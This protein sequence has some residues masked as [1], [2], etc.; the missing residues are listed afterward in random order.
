[1]QKCG[2]DSSPANRLGTIKWLDE[3]FHSKSVERVQ[4]LIQ[5]SKYL[6]SSSYH[7]S[8]ELDVR[9]IQVLCVISYLEECICFLAT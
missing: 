1:M 6:L 5:C 2:L 3:E 4:Q 7:P 8:T 9:T